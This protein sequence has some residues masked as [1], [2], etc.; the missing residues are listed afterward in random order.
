MKTNTPSLLSRPLRCGSI[1]LLAFFALASAPLASAQTA[2]LTKLVDFGPTTGANPKGSLVKGSDGAFYGVAQY[3]G[4]DGVG[5][6]FKM[7]AGGVVTKL[8]DFSSNTTGSYPQGSLVLGSD[9]AF[10]GLAPY[11]GANG[12]GTAFKLTPAGVLTK[13][14][15]FNYSTTGYYPK[16]SLVQGSDGAFYGLAESGGDYGFGTAFKVTAA[17]ELT[18]LADFDYDVTGYG[19]QG[20]LVQGSDGA[21]Y[22]VTPAGGAYGYG[23]A[24][25]LTAAGQLTALADFDYSNTGY[26]PK[27]SLV[28]GSDGA[29]YGLA[30]G[31]GSHGYGTA[32]RLTTEGDLTNLASLT[33]SDGYEPQG[34][35]VVGSDGNFYGL[36]KSGGDHSYGTAFKLTPAGEVTKLADFDYSNNIGYS[37]TGSLIQGSDGAFFG[38]TSEGGANGNG[39]AFT[40]DAGLYTYPGPLMSVNGADD[41]G[42]VSYGVI[43]TSTNSDRVFT[44]KN[45]GNSPLTGIT[46]SVDGANSS[47]FTII[48]PPQATINT[49]G[50]TTTF[51]VRFRSSTSGV[52]TADL[53]IASNDPVRN[54]YDITLTASALPLNWQPQF[55]G[56]QFNHQLKNVDFINATTGW[57]VGYGGLIRRTTDGGVTWSQQVS[58]GGETLYCVSFVNANTGWVSGTYGE[59]R[60]TTNGGASWSTQ[61][62]ATPAHGWAVFALNSTTAWQAGSS[63]MLGRTTNGVTWTGREGLPTGNRDYGMTDIQFADAN[64]GWALSGGNWSARTTDGGVSWTRMN[65]LTTRTLNKLDFISATTGWAV[66]ENGTI[67]KTTD[68]GVRW[69]VQDSGTTEWLSGVS[70]VDANTG[71]VVGS[72]GLILH[73][74]NGGTTWESEFSNTTTTLTDVDFVDAQHGW[75]VGSNG[76]IYAYSPPPAVSNAAP[77]ALTLSANSIA[78]NVAANST[79]GT[80]TTTDPDAGDSFTYSLVSGS[81]STDN[82]AFNISGSALRITSS[83][84]FETKSS[85]TVRVRTTDEGGLFF[86]KDF[87]ITITDANDA[88]TFAGYSVSTAF[89]KSVSMSLGK[90]LAKATDVEADAVT[91]TSVGPASAQGGTAALQSGSILYTPANGFSGSD[92]FPVTITDARGA[93]VIGTVTVNVQINTG[94]GG[95]T[96]VLTTMSGGRMGIGFQGIPGRSY[97]VQRSTDLNNWTTLTTVTAASNGAIVFIDNSP[98]SGSGFYRLRRP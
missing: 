27:G 78:E 34:D 71:W 55:V 61:T 14:A 22:G 19:P 77:T 42:S 54:P 56:T 52:R 32:F 97:E 49:P 98:P 73:T 4:A 26:G 21:F 43:A 40:I 41:G 83:P 7:T 9:G 85:Y 86:E 76:N 11:G 31:G 30:S 87:A 28:R 94:I 84:N 16:G 1:A 65:T 72:N 75:I 91:V 8:A 80:L 90:L 24:F 6:A 88:P 3:G 93:S 2:E 37:P 20:S 39:T 69:V 13:L 29:F 38:L 47:N 70:F 95:N 92:T 18:K 50:G 89:Q 64:T 15:D 12:A 60:K 45:K 67:I 96:P 74:T 62:P 10:Y 51:T 66:G 35:L 63:G 48:T 79:V 81:G 33:Y 25:K 17:G 36:A 82:A 58:G 23:T 44:I 59:L 46:V 68:G 5:T 53:H 57:A